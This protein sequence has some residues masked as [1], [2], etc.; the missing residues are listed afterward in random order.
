[1]NIMF[2]QHCYMQDFDSSASPKVFKLSYT[3]C[4]SG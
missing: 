2:K 1:M 4:M 3:R